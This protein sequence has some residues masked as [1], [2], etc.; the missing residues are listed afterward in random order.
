VSVIARLDK[1]EEAITMDLKSPGNALYII[2][3]TWRDMG[4]SEY[5]LMKEIEDGSVPQLR[6]PSRTFELYRSL[7]RAIQGG[8]VR[9][10]HDCSDGGLGVALA[11]MCFSGATGADIFL[12]RVPR[13]ECS[14]DT[15][16][17]FSET[18][19]RILVEVAPGQEAAFEHFFAEKQRCDIAKIGSVTATNVIRIAAVESDTTI[20]LEVS[21]RDAKSAWHSPLQF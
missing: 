17:L 13:K 5:A 20:S 6:R 9:S 14:T 18:P 3:T 21:L 10:C 1:P 15:E 16:V 19:G 2:G 12:S 8:V 7:H 4:A 11:E